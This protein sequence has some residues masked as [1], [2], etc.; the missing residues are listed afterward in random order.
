MGYVQA[1]RQAVMA[2]IN[3]ELMYDVLI[4]C[5]TMATP[6]LEN[7]LSHIRSGNPKKGLRSYKPALGEEAGNGKL[8]TEYFRWWMDLGT[9]HSWV[10]PDSQSWC[11]W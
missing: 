7:L 2:K 3:Q 5:R 8:G 9:V 11:L 1:G 4:S 6:E 10:S